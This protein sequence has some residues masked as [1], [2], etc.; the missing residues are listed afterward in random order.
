MNC[1]GR[2]FKAPESQL[3]LD[4]DYV[5]LP[6][7]RGLVGRSELV[8]RRFCYGRDG[9]QLNGNGQNKPIVVIGMLA[10]QIDAPWRTKT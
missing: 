2:N 4:A 5:L 8:L 10:N 1:N 7:L 9:L 3:L 6:A